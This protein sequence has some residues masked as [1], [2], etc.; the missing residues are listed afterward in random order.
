MDF[1]KRNRA[2]HGGSSARR[3]PGAVPLMQAIEGDGSPRSYVSA[4]I[5]AGGGGVRG[6]VAWLGLD[7]ADDHRQAP[8]EPKAGKHRAALINGARPHG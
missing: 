8:R 2:D 3:T 6:S 1:A 5:S 4:S 7:P